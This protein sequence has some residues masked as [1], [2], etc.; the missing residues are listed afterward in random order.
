M[1]KHAILLFVICLAATTA[2]AQFRIKIPKVNIP[3]VETPKT[4]EEHPATATRSAPAVQPAKSSGE[5][6]LLDS[7]TY[8]SFGEHRVSHKVVGWI[9]YPNFQLHGNIPNRS[10]V[11]VFVKKNGKELMNF[12]CEIEKDGFEGRL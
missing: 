7:K 10:G 3:Q 4:E 1:R 11:R 6:R 12:R 2:N 5:V 9:M 8:F